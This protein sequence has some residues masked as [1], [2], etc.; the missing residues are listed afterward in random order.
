MHVITGTIRKE[1]FTRTGTSAKGEWQLFAVE[2]SESW[3]DKEGNRQYSN[4]RASLFA[5]TPASINYN[6][7]LLV[8]G[9]I[10]S[11]SSET[12]QVVSREHNG[13]TYTHLEMINPKLV[14]A[15]APGADTQQQRSNNQHS[16]NNGWGRSQMH[17]N[18]AGNQTQNTNEPPMDFSDD[19]P[20]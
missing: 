15:R 2:L 6:K 8:E 18:T 13:K 10:V 20:F 3:K 17:N 14:F 1:P 5:S 9:A 16:H 11:I 12:L 4:Y 7:E 19:V